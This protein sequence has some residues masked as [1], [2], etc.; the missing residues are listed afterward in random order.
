MMLD[1]LEL[2][3]KTEAFLLP[4]LPKRWRQHPPPPRWVYPLIRK[5]RHYRR[6]PEWLTA[7]LT[8]VRK[9]YYPAYYKEGWGTRL[10]SHET[11]LIRFI[12]IVI[13]FSLLIACSGKTKLFS[14]WIK[15]GL[16]LGSSIL[17]IYG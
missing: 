1:I 2:V 12:L 10:A 17:F 7:F 16:L 5:L 3:R 6:R 11:R 15:G 14:P 4:L 9:R 8:S 13:L